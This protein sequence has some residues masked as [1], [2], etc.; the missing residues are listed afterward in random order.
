MIMGA[1]VA[2]LGSSAGQ[3]MPGSTLRGRDLAK[4]WCGGCRWVDQN[5]RWPEMLPTFKSIASMKSTTSLSLHVF[6]QRPHALM[7]DWRLT[8]E[9]IDD[10]VAYILSIRPESS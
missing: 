7:P 9:E 4:T 3:Q 5:Q 1:T 10:V 2:L 8:N 6:L